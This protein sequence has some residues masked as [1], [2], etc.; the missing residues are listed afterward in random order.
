VTTAPA[1]SPAS[2][3]TAGSVEIEVA[4]AAERR[5]LDGEGAPDITVVLP[6]YNEQDHVLAEIERITAAMQREGRSYE[7]LRSAAIRAR[8]RPAGSGP[9]TRGGP[10]WC[11][12]TR[13]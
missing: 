11:G 12:P 13:T 8:G 1:R 6:C 4:A 10:W 9:G 7:L 2:P 3:R 5:L